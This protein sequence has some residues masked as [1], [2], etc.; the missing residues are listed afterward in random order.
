MGFLS[1]SFDALGSARGNALNQNTLPDSF[2][3]AF[4]ATIALGRTS[5][6]RASAYADLA[7]ESQW[8]RR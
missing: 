8:L 2:D 4:V 3:A 1:A 6:G 7:D 5:F